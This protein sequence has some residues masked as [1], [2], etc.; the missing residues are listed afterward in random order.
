MSVPETDDTNEG[1]EQQYLHSWR[2]AVVIAMLFLGQLLLALDIN[3][4]NVAVPEISTHFKSLGDVAWYGSAYLLTITAFQPSFGA[5]YRFFTIDR[6][7]TVSIVIF[8]CAYLPL[9]S[10]LNEF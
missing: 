8:E 10:V 4:I 6:T 3:I 9:C 2:L 1:K 7:Y 5:M